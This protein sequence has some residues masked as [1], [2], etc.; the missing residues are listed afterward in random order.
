MEDELVR[1]YEVNLAACDNDLKLFV[2]QLF[3]AC[4]SER[5]TTTPS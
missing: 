5:K 3:E 2:R 1:I 4:G